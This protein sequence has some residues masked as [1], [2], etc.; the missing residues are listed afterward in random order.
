M[1][2]LTI[3]ATVFLPLRF[4]TGLLGINVARIPDAH[5]PLGFWVVGGF[6]LAVALLAMARL[7]GRKW[8]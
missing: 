4:V 6:L 5:D 1:P 7:R 3:L 2:K 8:M